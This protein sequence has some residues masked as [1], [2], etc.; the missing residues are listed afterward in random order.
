MA[1]DLVLN[2]TTYN[3]TPSSLSNPWKPDG[4]DLEVAKIGVSLVADDGTRRFVTR[5]TSKRTWKITW[6]RANETTRA[7]VRALHLL[8]TTWTM[9]DPLGVSYTVQ[10]E[11]DD[12]SEDYAMT[13]LANALRWKLE[14][15]VREA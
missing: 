10:T 13:T 11:Q 7:A 3:G 4:F 6:S 2:G 8:T 9:V 15:T 5:S 1:S 12:Y 14:L